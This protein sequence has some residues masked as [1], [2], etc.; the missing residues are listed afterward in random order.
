MDDKDEIEVEILPIEDEESEEAH[1]DA[2]EDTPIDAAV[3]PHSL[4]SLLPVLGL[5]VAAAII[6]AIGG[7]IGSQYFVKEPDYTS[8]KSEISQEISGA[9]DSVSRNAANDINALR[10]DIDKLKRDMAI[11]L[12]DDTLKTDIARVF[13]TLEAR[14]ATVE[15]RPQS[16]LPEDIAAI[17]PAT[18]SALQR[19]QEAG[20]NWPDTTSYEAQITV[21]QE[22]LQHMQAEVDALKSQEARIITGADTALLSASSESVYRPDF[23]LADLL[24][25]A[26]KNTKPK[27]LLE[28]TLDKHIR[29]ADPDDPV[30]LIKKAQK[31]YEDQDYRA[32]ISAFD[33]LPPEI[34][35]YGKNWREAI[36]GL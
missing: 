25:G 19:A 12:N 9:T 17:E 26:K 34:Q 10:S 15:A 7:A 20:F 8:L 31:A 36:G 21:L 33:Q 24:L 13:E 6:G 3:S 22:E 2:I 16:T 32:A 28:R 4:K 18:L 23:P 11:T 14:L 30:T 5:S 35:A 29:V 1:E 27:S